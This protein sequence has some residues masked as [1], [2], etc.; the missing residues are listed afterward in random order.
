MVFDQKWIIKLCLDSWPLDIAEI[1]NVYSIKVLNF[2]DML[3]H[4]HKYPMHMFFGVTKACVKHFQLWLRLASER[5]VL[6]ISV[7]NLGHFSF[8]SYEIVPGEMKVRLQ[9]ILMEKSLEDYRISSRWE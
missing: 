2:G 8:L 6:E 5:E 1:K 7:I 3:L 9:F 4:S